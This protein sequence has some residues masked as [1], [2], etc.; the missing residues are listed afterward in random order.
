MNPLLVDLG[1]TRVKWATP[2]PGGALRV[3]GD[4]PTAKLDAAWIRRL[5][6]EWPQHHLVLASVV[7]RWNAAFTRAFR[8]RATLVSGRLPQLRPLFAYRRPAELGAD[9]VAAAA[10]ARAHGLFPAI[11]VACGTATAYTVLDGK[12][13][14][15]G[16]AIAPGLQAQL[17]ALV[18]ATAQLPATSLRM[19]RSALAKST[20]D[21]I[22]AGVILSIQGG[23]KETVSRLAA[24][25]PRGTK[26]HVILTGG[27]AKLAANALGGK[28]TLRPLLVLEG[29]LIIASRRWMPAP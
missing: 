4:H 5:A 14:L 1:N 24:T 7:P 19:P 20:R 17:D 10:A 8:G 11:I 23:V 3:A 18:G 6:R 9:R 22:R 25:L 2:R 12:G 27:N 21:A 28:V 16:G 29:L 26:P 15:C 13:R